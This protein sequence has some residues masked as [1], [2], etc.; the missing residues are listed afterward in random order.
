MVLNRHSTRTFHRRLYSTELQSITLLKRG[1]DLQQNIVTKYQLFQCRRSYI[2]HTGE[3]IQ[4]SMAGSDTVIWHIP[5][6]E[7]GRVGVAYLNDLDRIVDPILNQTWQ[8]EAGNPIQ[9][10]LFGNQIRITCR[11]IT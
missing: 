10:K 11:R 1:D 9:I 4:G 7:L 5:K 3:T 8:P 6:I 2:T